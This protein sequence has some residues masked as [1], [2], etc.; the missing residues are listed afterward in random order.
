MSVSV[1]GAGAFGTALAISLAQKGGVTLWA[2]NADHVADMQASRANVL[3]LPGVDFPENMSLTSDISQALSADVILLAV[4]MQQ[5]AGFLADNI[6]PESTANLVACCKGFEVS[7][8]RG[9]VSVIRDAAPHATAAILTGPSFAAD[10]ARGLPTALTLACA[11][12]EAGEMLQ[13]ALTTPNLRLYRTTDTQGAELGG[14]LKNVIAI[15]CG[16]AIGAGLGQS[17]R[18]A[19]MTRGFS[20]MTRLAQHMGAET[21]TLA[22]LSGFGDL[23]LT[24]TSEQSRNYRLGLSLGAGDSFDPTT[25]VEGAA[26][27]RA[28]VQMT[29]TSGVDMPI[30]QTVARLLDGAADVPTSMAALLSR[31]LKEE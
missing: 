17:A 22:G 18:A 3:R 26:T 23:V 1:L 25:T 16:V 4:P 19:L 9:P 13:Q 2:R 27:A 28:I 29:Q 20:E 11:E 5:L 24:C 15:A 6:A 30:T 14:A 12:V 7:T 31:P 8:G 10:I 21:A